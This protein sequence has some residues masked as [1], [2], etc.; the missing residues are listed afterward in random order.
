M[1]E[2]QTHEVMAKDGTTW[3]FSVASQVVRGRLQ[4]QNIVRTCS[5][6]TAF[7]SAHVVRG[8]PLSSFRVLF[9]EAMLHH[10]QR[11]AIAEGAA[12]DWRRLECQP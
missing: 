8:S 3:K 1:Q 7:S 2:Q 5:G 12:S 11:F 10:L 6:P 9:D 4:Q